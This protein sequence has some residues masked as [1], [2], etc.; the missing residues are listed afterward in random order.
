MKQII[1][2]NLNFLANNK[3][4]VGYNFDSYLADVIAN[5]KYLDLI[6]DTFCIII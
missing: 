2:S 6:S 3:N 4:R 5:S 1:L